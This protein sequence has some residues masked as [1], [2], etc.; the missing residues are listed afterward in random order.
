MLNLTINKPIFKTIDAEISADDYAKLAL[1]ISN[2][3]VWNELFKKLLNDKRVT[4]R[5]ISELGK[6]IEQTLDDKHEESS[7]ERYILAISSLYST[8]KPLSSID[9]RFN[10]VISH[11]G[12]EDHLSIK[13]GKTLG[14]LSVKKLS[15]NKDAKDSVDRII[16]VTSVAGN[17]FRY[18]FDEVSLQYDFYGHHARL[19]PLINGFELIVDNGK[20]SITLTEKIDFSQDDIQQIL[21]TV[22]YAVS[23]ISIS[24]KEVLKQSE[25]ID[26][27]KGLLEYS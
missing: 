10:E 1:F 19:L 27:L 3:S 11:K 13:F 18:Q 6:S 14:E 4:Y 23:L 24:I 25:S 22:K 26:E 21:K 5:M 7:K 2:F 15:L 17:N 20:L 9:E 8:N 16:E 12:L